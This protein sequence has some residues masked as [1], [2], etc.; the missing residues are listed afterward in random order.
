MSKVSLMEYNTPGTL[1]LGVVTAA[2]VASPPL[3]QPRVRRRSL[4]PAAAAWRSPLQPR[5]CNHASTI[6]GLTGVHRCCR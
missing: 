2:A 5:A 1:A 6:L 3:P 4:A